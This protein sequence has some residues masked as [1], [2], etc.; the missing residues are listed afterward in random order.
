MS[1]TL[2]IRFHSDW[3][4]GEGAGVSGHIDRIVRRHTED[5]LPY[6]PAKTLT[7]IL[8]DACERVARGLDDGAKQGSWQTFLGELFGRESKGTADTATTTPALI[9]IGPAHLPA[10]LRRALVVDKETESKAAEIAEIRTAMTF[11]KPGVKL[12]AN[13]MAESKMLRLEEVV[14]GGAELEAM[15]ELDP[16]LEKDT[17]ARDAALALLT[18][19]ARAVERLGAKR[20]RGSGRCELHIDS[21]SQN[22]IELLSAAAPVLQKGNP[23]ELS[24]RPITVQDTTEGWHR[25]PLCV[26]LCAPMVI[27]AGT[28]GNVIA[29]R[30]HIPGTLLLPA[31]DARLRRLLGTRA[32][33]LTN[34]LA[35]GRIQIRN[36]YPEK[37]GERL[38]PVPA[39][40]MAEKEADEQIHNELHGRTHDGK[41]RKQLRAGY[42]PTDALPQP[43]RDT[44]SVYT[45]D[46]TAT[47]HA[48]I[49]DKVQRPTAE[50][51]G[52][53]TY[54]AIAPGQRFRAELWIA[55][56]TLQER[57]DG[58]LLE[59]P[60]R[61]G[62]AKKDDYG[63]ARLTCGVPQVT[64]ADESTATTYTFTLWLVS[65]LLARDERLRPITDVDAFTRWLDHRL[66][67]VGLHIQATGNHRAAYARSHREEGWN[68]AWK[69][70][71]PTRF[72][73]AAGTCFRFRTDIP[74]HR[75]LLTRI[76]HE[77]LGERRGEGYGEVQVDPPLLAQ[78]TVPRKPITED[79]KGATQPAAMSSGGFIERLHERAWRTAIRRQALARASTLAKE[80]G[81]KNNEPTPSQLGAL[82]SVFERYDSP[83]PLQR[84]LERL[85]K[86]QNRRDKW[87]DGALRVLNNFAKNSA[88]VWDSRYIDATQLP[89]LDVMD[90]ARLKGSLQAEATRILWLTAI[91]VEMD[92]RAEQNKKKSKEEQSHGA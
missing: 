26:E 9:W 52:V 33:E 3:H 35:A 76:A 78:A 73:L 50:V 87:N 30:D 6:I 66:G 43:Y 21:A 81:W 59:G 77:G 83:A 36:A 7:G 69:E 91:G 51:G 65:P 5:D 90:I 49:D 12:D 40:L 47:T 27:P 14:L 60:I 20:R 71:R 85:K 11:I 55:R 62:R 46:I 39:A 32:N 48:T 79:D 89:K 58:R 92:R 86:T 34:H 28:A 80:M 10:P 53:Y 57:P 75:T 17:Q 82:R 63:S 22:Y 74:I 42:V 37:W 68:N 24:L 41:Q 8:R 54:E 64:A 61:I 84:W 4:V 88:A 56:S 38:L 2:T 13:G 1:H 23:T 72:G 15:L 16:I 18:A 19:G 70:P 29:S 67:G 25:I 31:L 45:V 44:K